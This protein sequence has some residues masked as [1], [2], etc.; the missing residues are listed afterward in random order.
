MA[1]I[2]SIGGGKGGTGKSFF[3]G[4]LGILLAKQGYKTLV[5]DADLGT[6]NLHT[7]IGIPHPEKSLSDFLQKR[8]SSLE[9]TIL[10]TSTEN[11]D[12]ISGAMNNLDIANLAH[13]QKM[14]LIR[15][16]GE[17]SYDYILLDLGAGTSYNTID[18]FTISDFGIFVTTPEPTSIENIYRLIRSIYFRKIRQ[19]MKTHDFRLLL[20]EVKKKIASA[21]ISRPDILLHMVKELQPEKANIL[22]REL[23]TLNFKLAVNQARKHD[24]PNIGE[25][26]C[27]II[28]RH[29][30]LKMSFI[31]NISFDDHV[32]NAVCKKVP[33]IE[34]YPYSQTSLD[35]RDCNKCLFSINERRSVAQNTFNE[36]ETLSRTELL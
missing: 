22:E 20:D 36:D 1:R 4:N 19:S 29:L 32:H 18:F 16:I 17:L 28:E 24:N 34:L 7:I 11:L 3:T 8:V 31:G 30:S 12:L 13:E 10:T 33:F 26:I 2:W 9:D 6:A 21:D 25:L 15:N 5:I 23:Q 14:K 27:K 35:L